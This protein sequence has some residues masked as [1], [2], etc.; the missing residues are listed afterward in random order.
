MKA[1]TNREGR[2][3]RLG[4]AV[5]TPLAGMLSSAYAFVASVLRYQ[6]T[7]LTSRFGMCEW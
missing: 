6:G 5:D 4:T 7:R 2:P 3:I 1:A